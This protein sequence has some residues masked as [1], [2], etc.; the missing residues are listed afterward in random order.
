MTT[1][2]GGSPGNAVQSNDMWNVVPETTEDE[3]LRL[4]AHLIVR[5]AETI[6]ELFSGEEFCLAACGRGTFCRCAVQGMTTR[7]DGTTASSTPRCTTR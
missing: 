6:G 1:R 5:Y 3:A 4:L 2:S 7:R